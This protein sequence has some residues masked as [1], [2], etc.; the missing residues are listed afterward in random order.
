[1]SGRRLAVNTTVNDFWCKYCG[2]D[3][4]LRIEYRPERVLVAKPL[5][6][7]SL[8]GQQPKF[9]VIAD[10]RDWPYA[11]CDNCKRES[12]GRTE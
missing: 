9:S 10:T 5:G 8:S 4:P 6:T 7:F 11:V 1:V 12:R 3:Y 2:P